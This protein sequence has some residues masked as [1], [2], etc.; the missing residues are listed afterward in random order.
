MAIDVVVGHTCFSI[1]SYELELGY[2]CLDMMDDTRTVTVRVCK[3]R[4]AGGM[5][6]SGGGGGQGGQGEY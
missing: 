5:I 1:I 6:D 3:R 4:G 2:G